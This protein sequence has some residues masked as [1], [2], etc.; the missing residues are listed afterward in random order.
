MPAKKTIQLV[1]F[2]V[3]SMNLLTLTSQAVS[4]DSSQRY[5]KDA[6]GKPVFLIGYYDWASIAQNFLLGS[7]ARYQDMINAGGANGLNYIRLSLGINR[8]PETNSPIPF[9]V[10]NGKTDLDQW[11]PVFWAGLRYHCELARQKGMLVHIS[12]FDGVDIRAGGG[13]W[14][15]GGSFWNIDNH[16]RNFFGDLDTNNNGNVDQNGDFYR[17]ND[18]NNNTGIG[19][20]QR[21]LIDK[22]IA[23]T[24]AY[25]NVFFEVGNEL[26]GAPSDWNQAVVA[27]MKSKTSKPITQNQGGK[28]N[29]HDG[30]AQHVANSL[31]GLK[32]SVTQITEKGYPAWEDPD[33]P[34]F[35]MNG[36]ADSNRRA[37]WVS[38]VG[39]AAGWGGF[40]TD[41][42]NQSI[43]NDKLS[44]Y[45]Y[46][47]DFI[48]DSG[49][50]FWK[51]VASHNLV[52]N[53][54]EN[55]CLAQSGE[56]YVVYVLNDS[57]VSLDLR[58]V[59]G[60]SRAKI[61]NPKTGNWMSETVV[62]GGG[63]RTFTKPSGA[64]DWVVYVR[65]MNNTTPASKPEAPSRL[66]ATPLSPSAI[67]LSWTD[68]SSNETIFQI[69]RRKASGQYVQ[70]ANLSSDSTTFR[71]TGLQAST[72]YRYQ[73]RALNAEGPSAYSNETA[74]TTHNNNIAPNASFTVDR[75]SGEAPV[76]V[77]CDASASGDQ[78]GTIAS[79]AWDFGDGS[80]ASGVNVS[81]TCKKAGTFTIT[82][83]VTDNA[84]MRDSAT[85]TVVITEPVENIT[86]L[87]LRLQGR[88]LP[89]EATIKLDVN[90]PSGAS[91]TATMRLTVFDADNA[92]EGHLTINGHD[93]IPLF[94]EL[95]RYKND[96]KTVSIA[97]STPVDWWDDGANTLRFVHTRSGGYKVESI[98]VDFGNNNGG[99]STRFPIILKGKNLP[100]EAKVNLYTGK[101]SAS[102]DT[103]TLTLMVFDADN[104]NEGRLTINGHT[105]ITLF[106]QLARHQNDR[107]TVPI[108]LTTPANWWNDGENTL[109]FEHT[110]TGGFT[111][112]S[113]TVD[114]DD[115]NSGLF[116]TFPVTLKGKSLPEEA[117]VSLYTSKSSEE[118]DLAT[119]T[120]MVFDADNANEGSLVINGHDPIALFG[121]LARY[122]ND[123]KTVPITLTT[124][125]DWW[126]DGMNIL[127]FVHTKSGGY[128]IE[129][130]SVSFQNAK[131]VSGASSEPKESVVSVK[132]ART[133]QEL[134]SSSGVDDRN[135]ITGSVD[136]NNPDYPG[137][138][139]SWTVYE[140]AEDLT[141][142]GWLQYYGGNVESISNGAGGSE[143]AI[144]ISGDI[145]NDV[146]RLGTK[147]GSDWNNEDEFFIEF[148]LKLNEQGSGAVYVQLETSS[149]T[150]YLVYTDHEMTKANNPELIYI[151]IGDI[152][153]GRWHKNFR[154]LEDD[155]M[156]YMPDVQL[157]SV[158]SL[159][160]Y[161]SL[162]L[163]NVVLLDF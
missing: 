155:L 56:E 116:A 102:G 70:I 104:A 45:G 139:V 76:T 15:W 69:Q 13:W 19:K 108:T 135:D 81:H 122:K 129:S 12:I 84:G 149:G 156:T 38:F 148:C 152:A 35:F 37:A 22:A 25:D 161:G 138:P 65:R 21:R 49:V 72:T 29:N 105:P 117:T 162:T 11:D 42:W 136:F 66:V 130:A 77:N 137:K 90:K 132:S 6:S 142:D 18:F 89:E 78:D 96:A 112:E 61:Y 85:Q 107:R 40:S 126:K 79:Y 4:I 36:N 33:G 120:L 59:G 53:N 39:G 93:P 60:D 92:N 51:M 23:E 106:G 7:P 52:S 54:S 144:A 17:V 121:K 20:Y 47:L 8:V 10:R 68:N 159:F 75:N 127:R 163:D 74:V 147:D 160:V 101:S 58:S 110:S 50:E 91:G 88:N 98:T 46:L 27:Y 63:T 55:S 67:D 158:K 124:P 109:Q 44:Y 151:N 123:R 16:A 99:S 30:W 73:V 83:T 131:N 43:D 103:A 97:L 3:I 134:P 141:T 34:S 154:S 95:A 143:R 119:L 9:K 14:R 153:D 24:A 5:F 133:Y 28:A 1:V 128:A 26:F 57:S 150:Q 118:S 62:P 48:A 82:L 32:S 114:F 80:K 94:G 2:M 145:E 115:K 100:E 125:A 157:L 86:T 71:D 111:I 113:I 41:F 31:S 146:F 140:D 64:D 87:P